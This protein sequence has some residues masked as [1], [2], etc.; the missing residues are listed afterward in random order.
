MTSFSS[1]L[2]PDAR[3]RENTAPTTTSTAPAAP[4]VATHG[5][6][7]MFFLH[8][9]WPA[10]R[11]APLLPRGLVL[12][13]F[14]G[15]AYLTVTPLRI[16][17]LRPRGFP[18]FLGLSFDEVTVRTYVRG[19]GGRGMY[20]LSIESDSLLA[21]YVARALLG[22][23]YERARIRH[24]VHGRE[25]GYVSRR[26]DSDKKAIAVRAT[27]NIETAHLPASPL[28]RF[29]LERRNVFVERN[30]ALHE[31]VMRHPGLQVRSGTAVIED[32][33]LLIAEHLGPAPATR[34]IVHVADPVE[35]D[36]LAPQVVEASV[37]ELNRAKVVPHRMLPA[38]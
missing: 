24:E 8:W 7:D 37:L 11:L 2:Q 6:R 35:V 20:F 38:V 9:Q 1:M 14:D 13:R 29:L 18:A 34:P 30:G 21:S 19:L 17:R 15:D 26:P 16:E 22:L 32:T 3:E 25:I 27:R 23:P 4:V 28:E 5:W 31:I 12:D 10:A 33:S 36:V